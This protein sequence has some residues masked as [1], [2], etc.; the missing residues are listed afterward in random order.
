LR[1]GPVGRHASIRAL[2][3]AAAGKQP[4]EAAERGEERT[5]PDRVASEEPRLQ[6]ALQLGQRRVRPHRRGLRA[7]LQLQLAHGTGEVGRRVEDHVKVEVLASQ[8][9]GRRNATAARSGGEQLG[10]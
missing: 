7:V 10:G 9:D 2:R 3:A 4:L 6:F 8:R 1:V 5:E